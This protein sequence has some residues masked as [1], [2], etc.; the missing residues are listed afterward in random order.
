[1][2][3][4]SNLNNSYRYKLETGSK[5]HNCPN[6]GKKTYVRYIDTITGVYLPSQY[7]R[8]DRECKCCYHLNPYQDGYAKA[9]KEEENRITD[10][11]KITVPEKK[12]FSTQSKFQNAN[13]VF[14]PFEILMQTLIPEKYGQNLFIQNLL[15]KIAFPFEINDIEKVIS[16]YYLGTV[17]N[18]Y[19]AGAITFPFIDYRGH[20][21]A[22]QVKQ[23]D[24]TNHT[25][26]TDFLHAILEKHYARKNQRLPK[27]LDEY[28]KQEKIVSCLFGE[29]LLRIYPLN[30]VALVEA[31][32][33]AIYST[34]Y[35]GF[36]EQH[37]NFLWL[38]VY[39]KSSFSLDK[40]KVLQGRDV[41][42]FPDLSINGK[43]FKEWE[44]KANDYKNRL[45]GT[46]FIFCDLLENLAP[47]M[48][49]KKGND[50][51]DYLIKLD[52]R[53]FRQSEKS[54]QKKEVKT[55]T[56]PVENKIRDE[57][58][59]E[60]EPKC[61]TL[62]EVFDMMKKIY[63]DKLPSNFNGANAGTWKT[64]IQILQK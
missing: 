13:P 26:G 31:P 5:K 53:L 6:C 18:G 21:R 55:E 52:W 61:Q 37:K 35:F 58:K 49:K 24:E 33:T 22:I 34:L 62:G 45:S 2:S 50:L 43:A 54:A 9:I 39:N 42:T 12:I 30:P 15:N 51:A 27:W 4:L 1:M 47:E 29:H 41:Y 59:V 7:G 64:Q 25:T 28:H 19:R 63:G 23:F 3:N 38:A 14:I 10:I 32:K 11:T 36:P 40:L 17:T 56:N 20:I 16:L 44:Y 8:C 60:P 48:D 57:F 46:R